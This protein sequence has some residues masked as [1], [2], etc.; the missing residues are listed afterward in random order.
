MEKDEIEKLV[1]EIIK[2]EKVCPYCG[3]CPT[4]GR[5]P[6]DNWYPW[7]YYLY[8]PYTPSITSCSY[9][10]TS[11]TITWSASGGNVTTANV[12]IDYTTT[13]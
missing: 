7:P 3:R 4:C 13:A 2:K 5:G 11:P 12:N 10:H 9:P 1:K 8:Y 6:N